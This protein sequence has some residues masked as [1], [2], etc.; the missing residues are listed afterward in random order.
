MDSSLVH[1]F[2]FLLKLEIFNVIFKF[3]EH[4]LFQTQT[5]FICFAFLFSNHIL[6][7]HFQLSFWHEKKIFKAIFS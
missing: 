4:A 1:K 5:F 3:S 7:T 6:H 2:F